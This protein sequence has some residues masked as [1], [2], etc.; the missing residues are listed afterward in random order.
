MT[1]T[2]K[3]ITALDVLSKDE[4]AAALGISPNNVLLWIR[5]GKIRATKPG[6]T[7]LI[8]RAEVERVVR[9]INEGEAP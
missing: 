2:E 5:D 7:Y 3:P 9:A 4:A 8:P 6:R 1:T